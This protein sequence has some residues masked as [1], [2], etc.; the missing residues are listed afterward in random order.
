MAP[1]RGCGHGWQFTALFPATVFDQGAR[2]E[3]L[4]WCALKC[5]YTTDF[6]KEINNN[7]CI[8]F[9][10]AIQCTICKSLSQVLYCIVI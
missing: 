9:L 8:R 3:D 7:I 10:L 4:N 1:N 2:K 5:K 6:T